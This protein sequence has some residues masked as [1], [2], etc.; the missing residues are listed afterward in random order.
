MPKVI[1]AVVF[2]S[3][4]QVAPAP[5][6]ELVRA[7]I[8]A[9]VSEAGLDRSENRRLPVFVDVLSFLDRVPEA[10]E[11]STDTLLAMAAGRRAA[12]ARFD[13]V[14]ECDR[15][16]RWKCGVRGNG[17]HV[18]LLELHEEDGLTKA[19]V[20]WHRATPTAAVA[21]LCPRETI[22]AFRRQTG[23]WILEGTEAALVC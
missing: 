11:W 14:R 12:D 21:G 15:P 17:L 9:A 1:A 10:S 22:F 13:Q 3:L 7:I 2:L 5:D 19:H 4:A 23:R 20:R 8:R 18:E 16:G 6:G